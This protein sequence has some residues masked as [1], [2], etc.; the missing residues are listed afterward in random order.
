[1]NQIADEKASFYLTRQVRNL[2]LPQFWEFCLATSYW[3][4]L[5]LGRPYQ[6]AE[7]YLSSNPILKKCTDLWLFDSSVGLNSFPTQESS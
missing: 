2:R 5:A 1:M 3:S 6:R 7:M 4:G